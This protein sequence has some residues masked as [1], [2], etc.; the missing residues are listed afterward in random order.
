MSPPEGA[1]ARRLRNRWWKKEKHWCLSVSLF[2]HKKAQI[3]TFC[4][5]YPNSIFTLRVDLF[6]RKKSLFGLAVSL[7]CC[8]FQII[9]LETNL[10]MKADAFLS[11]DY[12]F[13]FLNLYFQFLSF[14]FSFFLHLSLSESSFHISNSS[15][16]PSYCSYSMFMSSYCFLLSMFSLF[17]FALKCIHFIS[18]SPLS[19][20]FLSFYSFLSFFLSVCLFFCLNWQD[21]SLLRSP[22]TWKFKLT[23]ENGFLPVRINYS[24]R[25]N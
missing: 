5:V 18:L 20:L 23:N 24:Q 1:F 19:V 15:V 2:Q 22:M 9:A 16:I 14:S 8:P 6:R 3:L 25:L 4:I 13:L 11:L 10:V 17:V 12:I 21:P 7:S